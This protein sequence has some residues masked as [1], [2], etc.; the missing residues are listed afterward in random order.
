MARGKPHPAEM[1][2]AVL[3][4][5]LS[6]QSVDE[7]AHLYSLSRATV[8]AWRRAAGLAE[9]DTPVQRKVQRKKAEDLGELVAAFLQETL[10]TL[11]VQSQHFRDVDWLRG[12]NAADLAVL[13]GV[14]A[15]KAFRLLQ[16]LQ[17]D[18]DDD[19]PD[20]PTEAPLAGPTDPQAGE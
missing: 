15:D 9:R 6:G 3:A 16:A 2:S 13:H 14:Q 10:V 1:R 19:N 4:A 17:S 5:L 7:V 20:E 11:S 18:D 12:Q 8:V